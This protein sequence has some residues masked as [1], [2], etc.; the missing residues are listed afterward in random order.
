MTSLAS[1]KFYA[2]YDDLKP[3]FDHYNHV[4]PPKDHTQYEDAYIAHK[5]YGNVLLLHL[6][7]QTT[8]QSNLAPLIFV[9]QQD[10]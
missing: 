5:Q 10:I 8:I 6:S 2:K 3:K 9:K 1:M 7:K 4:V